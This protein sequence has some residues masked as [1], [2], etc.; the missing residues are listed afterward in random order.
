MEEKTAVIVGRL[1]SVHSPQDVAAHAVQS[2]LKTANWIVTI[3]EGSEE[4]RSLLESEPCRVVIVI[5][6]V[7]PD[8]YGDR[9]IRDLNRKSKPPLIILLVTRGAARFMVQPRKTF[10][11]LARM[12]YVP[13]A[14][15]SY[16]SDLSDV[17]RLV[18]M[19]SDPLAGK[20]L[21]SSD[22]I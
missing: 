7:D 16:P 10:Y 11:D 6:D 19:I 15:V 9:F 1:I 5:D 4:A 21:R 8:E 20:F 2:L 18:E 14:V 12:D 17:L 3:Q 22:P 13:S